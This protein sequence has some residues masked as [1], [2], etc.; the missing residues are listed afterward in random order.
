M[1]SADELLTVADVAELFDTTADGVH[2]L[3]RRG[4]LHPVRLPGSGVKRPRRFYLLRSEVMPLA[5]GA[6]RRY[7]PR[8]SSG[9]A[10][11]GDGLGRP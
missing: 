4:D 8:E 9:G 2:A 10:G 1:S 5:N 7:R 6:W 3:I 11:R